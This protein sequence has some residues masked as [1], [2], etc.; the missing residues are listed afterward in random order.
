MS[1][2]GKCFSGA[3]APNRHAQHAQEQVPATDCKPDPQRQAA[4]RAHPL[5]WEIRGQDSTLKLSDGSRQH[6]LGTAAVL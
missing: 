3:E 1:K 5:P 6:P 2:A 4:R